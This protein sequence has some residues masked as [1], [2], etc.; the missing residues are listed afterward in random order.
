MDIL[1][2]KVQPI[3]EMGES[4]ISEKGST[5]EHSDYFAKL[6]AESSKK[7]A[8]QVKEKTKESETEKVESVPQK[9]IDAQVMLNSYYANLHFI[10]KDKDSK[11]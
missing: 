6:L 11:K 5:S 8:K 4:Q 9:Q 3:A 2:N 7:Y 10:K 1:I